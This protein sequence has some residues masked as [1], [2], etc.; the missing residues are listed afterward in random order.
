MAILKVETDIFSSIVSSSRWQTL[1]LFSLLT[2]SVKFLVG[3]RSSFCICSHIPLCL[4][5]YLL[6]ST[7][8]Q[9]EMKWSVIWKCM[10]YCRVYRNT[11]Q[12]M[13]LK[14][15]GKKNNQILD[16]IHFN[17]DYYIWTMININRHLYL[18]TK[19]SW[20]ITLCA[21]KV[22]RSILVRLKLQYSS[23]V[24]LSFCCRHSLL[25]NVTPDFG[26]HIL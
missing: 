19:S 14:Y 21:S 8:G 16:T 11:F 4:N 12:E 20:R 5:Q 1:I 25:L 13:F 26:A 6:Y 15:I 22:L 18:S 9:W 10:T 24:C 2:K 23:T 17:F 3:T 7:S